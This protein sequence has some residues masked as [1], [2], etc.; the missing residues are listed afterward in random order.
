MIQVGKPFIPKESIT[1]VNDALESG[2]V[3]SLGKYIDK[4]TDFLKEKFGYKYVLLTSNGTC[5]N[6]LMVKCLQ[7]RYINKNIFCPN[8]VY[9]AAWNPFLQEKYHKLIFI[10]LI[11]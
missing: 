6:H 4:C 11:S 10:A 3:S 5:S 1:Y 7:Y 8:N 2:W 9:V